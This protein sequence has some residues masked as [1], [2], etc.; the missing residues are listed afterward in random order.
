MQKAKY[1]YLWRLLKILP[2]FFLNIFSWLLHTFHN[3]LQSFSNYVYLNNMFYQPKHFETHK[4]KKF[5][6]Y[7]LTS[8]KSCFS[9]FTHF[10]KK[11]LHTESKN[12]FYSKKIFRVQSLH[13]LGILKKAECSPHSIS[14]P[15]LHIHFYKKVYWILVAFIRGYVRNTRKDHFLY[16]KIIF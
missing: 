15:H 5:Q 2:I 9:R 13:S 11:Q 4:F 16:F 10:M 6:K 7:Q 8:K 12:I 3:H 14:T 1:L